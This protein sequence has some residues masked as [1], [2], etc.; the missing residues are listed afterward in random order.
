MEPFFTKRYYGY[1]NDRKKPVNSW[2]LK[3]SQ[4]SHEETFTNGGVELATADSAS[5]ISCNYIWSDI[6]E[7]TFFDGVTD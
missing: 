7:R 5:Q 3:K 2:A 4:K 1:K 6:L